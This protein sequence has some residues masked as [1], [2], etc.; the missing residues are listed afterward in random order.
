VFLTGHNLGEKIKNDP[1]GTMGDYIQIK[2]RNTKR[3]Y[4]PETNEP[5]EHEN[6]IV[7]VDENREPVPSN[8]LIGTG[9]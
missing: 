9:S 1:K 2:A 6:S 3:V 4:N 5:D 8:V 7:V